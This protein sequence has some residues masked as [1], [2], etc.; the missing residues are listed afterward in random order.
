M[1]SGELNFDALSNVAYRVSLRGAGAE[2]SSPGAPSTAPLEVSRRCPSGGARGLSAA[3][4]TAT[5]A[6]SRIVGSPAAESEV[7]GIAWS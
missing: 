7:E 4:L 1:T 2:P 6:G 5:S 3:K